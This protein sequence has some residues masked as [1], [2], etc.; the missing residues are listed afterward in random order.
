VRRKKVVSLGVLSV[1]VFACAAYLWGRPPAAV[2]E[3]RVEVFLNGARAC[4]EE[5]IPHECL[6]VLVLEKAPLLGVPT[7]IAGI[8]EAA[9]RYPEAFLVNC[10]RAAHYLGEYAGETIGVLDEALAL[11][12]PFCQFGYYHGVVEGYARVTPTLFEELPGLCYHIDADVTSTGHAECSHSLGHAIV[13]RTDNDVAEGIRY[14]RALRTRDERKACATG[15]FMSWSNSLDKALHAR[16]RDGSP[17]PEKFL[18]APVDQRWLLCVP[19][20]TEMAEACVHFLAETAPSQPVV[21][22]VAFRQMRE[23]T[24]WCEETFVGRESVVLACHGAVGRVAGADAVFGPL[25]G[26]PGVVEFCLS[27]G[28]SEAFDA[29]TTYAYTSG[30]QFDANITETACRAWDGRPEQADQ[31]ALIRELHSKAVAPL[32]PVR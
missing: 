22:E 21:G 5:M 27:A 14:C 12:D 13:T 26:W 4:T 10:H 6:N 9:S 11:G 8:G 15:I 3:E 19:L 18:I 20:D 17:V 1:A 7:L 25:G 29:C 28:S 16:D 2:D 31:C 23:F 24:S 30:S 32:D